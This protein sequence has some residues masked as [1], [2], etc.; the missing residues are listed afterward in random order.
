M[1][2]LTIVVFLVA[3]FI[4]STIQAVS[5]FGFGI[6]VMTIFPYLMPSAACATV[7]TMLSLT[8]CTVIAIR[9]RKQCN[10]RRILLPI[11][12]NFVLSLICISLSSISPDALLRR[13]LAVALIVLSIYFLF[14]S[15]KIRLKATPAA[16][17]LAGGASGMLGG[18]FAMGGPPIVLY[19]LNAT[20]DNEHY[21]ADIQT[22]MAVTNIYSVGVRAA[23]GMVTREVCLWWGIGIAAML[24]GVA[25]GRAL[26]HR[27][28]P[29]MLKRIV[30]CYMALSGVIMF[31]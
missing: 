1:S 8:S 20:E 12:G 19:L 25:L 9:M 18:F 2:A 27:L 5:G 29:A 15:T 10:W 11:A 7:S 31:F 6:F 16:G 4:G 24:G 17:L 30:Y 14:F 22:Y 21:I 28:N 13:G 3:V 26:F 23:Q